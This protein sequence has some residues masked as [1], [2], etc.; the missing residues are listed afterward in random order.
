M[1]K[2]Q[3]WNRYAVSFKTHNEHEY[4]LNEAVIFTPLELGI[5][6]TIQTGRNAKTRREISAIIKLPEKTPRM[7]DIVWNPK[8]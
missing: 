1:K 8:P 4:A 5:G 2:K 7:G 6:Q 3:E